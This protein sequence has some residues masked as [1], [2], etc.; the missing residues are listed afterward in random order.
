MQIISLEA[1]QDKRPGNALIAKAVELCAARKCSYLTYGKLT[2]DNKR[3]SSVAQYKRRNGFEEILYPKY[4]V[5]ITLRGSVA[6]AVGLHLSWKRLIPE[7]LV[8]VLLEIRARAREHAA[9]RIAA[10]EHHAAWPSMDVKPK[11]SLCRE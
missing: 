10:V 6:L 2:Y 8:Y 1:H 9:R 3:N 5:P 4:Y 7:K 11:E